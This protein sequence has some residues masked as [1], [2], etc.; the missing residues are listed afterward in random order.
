MPISRHNTYHSSSRRDAA[1]IFRC[2][3]LILYLLAVIGCGPSETVDILFFHDEI[4]PSCDNYKR[5][6]MITSRIYSLKGT[7]I[8]YNVGAHNMIDPKTPPKLI[9]E[10]E[11]R[12]LSDVSNSIPIIL[13]D[14]AYYAGYEDIEEAVNKLAKQ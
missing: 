8:R 1:R 7:G 4:C 9:E 12:G 3:A 10:L 13:I 14:D 6:E 11:A 5:A 2:G